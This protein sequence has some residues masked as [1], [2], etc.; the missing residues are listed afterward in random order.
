NNAAGK[1]GQ[2]RIVRRGGVNTAKT[3]GTDAAQNLYLKISPAFK[4]NLKSVWVS[5]EYYDD[6]TDGF[7]MQYDG[8]SSS[9]AVGGPGVRFKYDTENFITQTWHITGFKLAGGQ[10]GGADLRINDRMADGT[11]D[12]PE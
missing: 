1:D 11:A 8:T 6:G 2:T 9:T 10:D 4:A 12:G 3:G 5:V 7:R